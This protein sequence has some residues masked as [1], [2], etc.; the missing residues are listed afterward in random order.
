MPGSLRLKRP[1]DVQH[2]LYQSNGEWRITIRVVL[3]CACGWTGILCGCARS[4]PGG[5][6]G[7]LK[8]S[9]RHACMCITIP[10]TSAWLDGCE[11]RGEPL[12]LCPGRTRGRPRAAAGSR[13]GERSRL[14][15]AQRQ[16]GKGHCD[17]SICC[18]EGGRVQPANHHEPGK[19]GARGAQSSAR[20]RTLLSPSASATCRPAPRRPSSYRR[21]WRGHP[22]L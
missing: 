10:R 12:Q 7:R 8:D 15:R 22:L 21:P 1:A 13:N 2:H 3:R 4:R 18:R 17:L 11:D 16:R 5:P 20:A 9:L 19:A 6:R 14:A